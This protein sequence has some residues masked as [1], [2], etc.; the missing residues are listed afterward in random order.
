VLEKYVHNISTADVLA[1]CVYKHSCPGCKPFKE[2]L[3]T[4]EHA[5]KDTEVRFFELEAVDPNLE[6]CSELGIDHVP[7]LVV[8]VGAE[9]VGKA[10]DPEKVVELLKSGIKEWE[11]R[12]ER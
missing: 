7:C 4:L 8:F 10:Y 1:L 5:F 3:L 11:K 2:M 12:K 6:L 9:L